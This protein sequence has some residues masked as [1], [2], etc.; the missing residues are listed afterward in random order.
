VVPDLLMLRY[1]DFWAATEQTLGQLAGFLEVG[2]SACDIKDAVAFAS[3]ENLR[4]REA[5]GFFATSRLQPR[6]AGNAESFKVRKGK[7]GGYQDYLSPEQSA[8]LEA[9][10]RAQLAPCFGYRYPPH[11]LRT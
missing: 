9:F 8:S 5:S 4:Q 1:E 7:V 11:S 3:L 6:Q 10:V 2:S